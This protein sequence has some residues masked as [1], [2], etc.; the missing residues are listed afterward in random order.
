M[1]NSP[2]DMV[3]DLAGMPLTV[4]M[5]LYF[6]D[7]LPISETA[8]GDAVG[9]DRKSARK[10]LL[11]LASRELVFRLRRYGGWDLT[12]PA[13]Q[14]KM[15]FMIGENARGKV[16]PSSG[17]VYPSSGNSSPSSG[18]VYPSSGNSSPSRAP[19]Y[20][21]RQIDRQIDRGRTNTVSMDFLRKLGIGGDLEAMAQVG[22]EEILAA[23]WAVQWGDNPRGLLAKHLLD[24]RPIDRAYVDLAKWRFSAGEDVVEALEDLMTD[25]LTSHRQAW[26]PARNE[27]PAGIDSVMFNTALVIHKKLGGLPLG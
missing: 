19:F 24:Q 9:C 11:L 21:D 8:V 22:P 1:Y 10:W 26:R 25:S 12:R 5:A 23:W 4:L 7:R 2:L 13:M 17:K 27:Y 16:S 18:K 14:L 20:I 15:Q 6:A 3:L